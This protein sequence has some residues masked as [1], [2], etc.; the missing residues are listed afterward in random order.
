MNNFT[1]KGTKII[2]LILKFTVYSSGI[3]VGVSE[4][5]LGGT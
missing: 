4:D 5:I 3:Q 1:F 2:Y